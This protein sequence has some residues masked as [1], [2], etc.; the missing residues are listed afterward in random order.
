[1]AIHT[2][3]IGFPQGREEEIMASIRDARKALAE[4]V[5]R[6][7][8]SDVFACGPELVREAGHRTKLT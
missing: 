8:I 4:D 5:A 3:L 1:M 2:R 6:F 7:T